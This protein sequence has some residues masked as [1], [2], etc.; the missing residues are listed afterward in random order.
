MLDRNGQIIGVVVGKLNAMKAAKL[1]GDLPQN[2]NFA[3]KGWAAV[4]FLEANG[5]RPRQG[6][7]ASHMSV[8]DTATLAQTFTVHLRC[9]G[10]PN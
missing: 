8:V 7:D 9:I 3:I 1:L 10:A 5:V 6:P 4:A 2:I